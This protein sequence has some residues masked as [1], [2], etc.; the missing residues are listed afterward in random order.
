MAT[1][2]NKKNPHKN[3]NLK[4]LQNINPNSARKKESRCII[5]G[6]EKQ[7]IPVETDWVIESI[8]WFKRNIT[9]NERNYNLIV[10]RECYPKH[11]KLYNSFRNKQVFYIVLGLIFTFLLFFASRYNLLSL[12]PGIILTGF[13][14]LLSL[15]SYTPK[16]KVN[17]SDKSRKT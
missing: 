5:C 7:G 9:R 15:L 17:I 14:Y 6:Q 12:I 11:N 3:I 10:C 8:R 16:V 4:S 1:K 13:L 2:N